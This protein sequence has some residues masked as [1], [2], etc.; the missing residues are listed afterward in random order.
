[1]KIQNLTAQTSYFGYEAHGFYLEPNGVSREMPPAMAGNT[2]LRADAEAGRIRILCDA[3]DKNNLKAMG[4]DLPTSEKPIPAQVPEARVTAVVPKDTVDM[5]KVELSN[6]V[7]S[8]RTLPEKVKYLEEM[9]LKGKPQAKGLAEE[10]L[11]PLKAQ[12]VNDVT[13]QP[14]PDKPADQKPAAPAREVKATEPQMNIGNTATG[15]DGGPEDGLSGSE[16]AVGEPGSDNMPPRTK[17][18][19]NMSKLEM[20]AYATTIGCSVNPTTSHKDLKETVMAQEKAK[21]YAFKK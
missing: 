1:M 15:V 7:A 5:M 12:L 6:F 16:G 20:L 18:L 2:Y 8:L 19:A 10:M 3:V 21:G 4:I 13:S 11:K 9:I 14:K 17:A